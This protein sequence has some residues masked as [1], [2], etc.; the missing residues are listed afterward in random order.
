MCANR[1][2]AWTMPAS[3]A[4]P[5]CQV[6]SPGSP[7]GVIRTEEAPTQTAG[8]TRSGDLS[9]ALPAELYRLARRRRAGEAGDEADGSS[10]PSELVTDPARMLFM[11]RRLERALLSYE[12]AGW[13]DDLPTRVLERQE[14]RPAAEQGPILLCLDT[15]GSMQGEPEAVAKAVALEAARAALRQGRRCVLFAF[16]C[17]CLGC[18]LGS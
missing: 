18:E 3:S 9:R 5:L 6:L 11:A 16:R 14:L 2:T 13:T 1:V 8:L 10:A 7:L 4:H 15:S 17:A 12:R